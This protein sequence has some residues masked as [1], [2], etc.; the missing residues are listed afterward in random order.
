MSTSIQIAVARVDLALCQIAALPW[1]II[2]A[3]L[4]I[5]AIIVKV[6]RETWNG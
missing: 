4:V 5:A 1:G 6:G 3:S 2:A